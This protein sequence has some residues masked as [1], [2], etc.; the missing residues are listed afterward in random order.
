MTKI[1]AEANQ[2]NQSELNLAEGIDFLSWNVMEQNFKL[3][4][5]VP[6]AVLYIYR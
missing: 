5:R 2:T 3:E 6:F 1:L 4:K